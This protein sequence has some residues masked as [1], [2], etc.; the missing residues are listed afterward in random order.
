MRTRQALLDA[1]R[2]QLLERGLTAVSVEEVAAAA[3]VSRRTFFNYFTS[4]EAA[5]SE[6]I[7]VPIADL[8]RALAL[9][10]ADEPPLVAV[11]RVLAESPLPREMLRWIAAVQC[12]DPERHGMAVNVWAYHREQLEGIFRERLGDVDELTVSSL[13]GTVM[14]VF[15]AAER[16]WLRPSTEAGIELGAEINDADSARFNALLQHGLELAA[17]GWNQSEH[18]APLE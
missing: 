18:M 10:P 14:A 12:S 11:R 8:A 15:E 16:V 9:R 17:S 2:S 4:M 1:L 6:A 3:E 7:S 13:T 5:L